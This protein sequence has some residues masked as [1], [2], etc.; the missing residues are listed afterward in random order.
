MAVKAANAR[1]EEA[2]H[3]NSTPLFLNFSSHQLEKCAPDRATAMSSSRI[4]LNH[5]AYRV[6]WISALP[7][8]K[9]AAIAMLDADHASLPQPK[10]DNNT[11]HLGEIGD[12]NIVIACLP[13]GRYGLTSAAVVSQQMLST[14]PSIEIGLMVGIGGGVPSTAADI[15]L[16]DIVVSKPTGLFPGVVQYDYGKTM[17]NG[18]FHRTGSLNNPPDRHLDCNF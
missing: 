9:T 3:L 16:G 11:Y 14:F 4:R 17:G 7:L 6:G 5:D 15:R 2:A 13:S 18:S 8:E 10:S 12:H 1:D